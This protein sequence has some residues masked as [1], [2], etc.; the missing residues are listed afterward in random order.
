VSYHVSIL[1]TLRG[2]R[3]PITESEF[4]TAISMVGGWKFAKEKGQITFSENEC[5]VVTLWCSDGTLW[6]KNPTD[7]A[8]SEMLRLAAV[9]S[10]RVRGDEFETYRTPHDTYRH[11]DDDEEAKT[12]ESVAHKLSKR[13]RQNQRLLNASIIVMFIVMGV[14]ASRCSR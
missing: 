13:V 6:T 9:L 11:P 10:A 14:L 8:I 2:D 1:R 7:K 12:A 4:E 3:Q 5:E